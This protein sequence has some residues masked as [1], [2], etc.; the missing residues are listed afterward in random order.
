MWSATDVGNILILMLYSEHN[1]DALKHIPGI[2]YKTL[3]STLWILKCV[4]VKSPFLKYDNQ[5]VRAFDWSSSHLLQRLILV[6][7]EAYILA[8]TS[9]YLNGVFF[10]F[11]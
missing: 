6:K 11:L 3:K 9:D 10:T 5:L 2:K 4:C 7:I 1:L 8:K